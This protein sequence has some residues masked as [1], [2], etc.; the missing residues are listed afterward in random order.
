MRARDLFGLFSAWR[1][2]RTQPPPLAS[3]HPFEGAT[4]AE[5]KAALAGA[6]RGAYDEGVAAEKTRT[7][8]ILQASGAKTFP[9]IAVDL[10]LG[11]AT[12]EQAAGVLARAEAD[13]A[14]RAGLIKSNLLDRASADVPT[15]H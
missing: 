9:D 14:T 1:R 4:E 5:I 12:G 15:L 8:A 3:G 13:A 2:R 11:P 7:E 10:V 6:I